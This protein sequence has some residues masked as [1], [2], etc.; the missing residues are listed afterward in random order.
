MFAR[1]FSW[2]LLFTVA[3]LFIGNAVKADLPLSRK[4]VY[5]IREIP[6]NPESPIIFT[7]TL[8]LVAGQISGKAVAWIVDYAVFDTVGQAP[9]RWIKENPALDTPDGLWWVEHEDPLNPVESE[10]GVPPR[11]VG[12]AKAQ[13]TGYDDLDYGFVGVTPPPTSSQALAQ[14]HFQQ[15]NLA[16]PEA[17]SVDEEPVDV[18]TYGE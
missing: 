11:L 8:R 2:S 10:F 3:P 4:V 14:Y 13:D 16:D 6:T 17:E 1:N 5:S 7:V 15:L 18:D 12:V 9:K